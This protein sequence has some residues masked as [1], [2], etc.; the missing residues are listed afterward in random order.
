MIR[1]GSIIA[2]VLTVL[3]LLRIS[4]GLAVAFGTT[5]ESNSV[6]A[7]RYLA[8]ANTGEA[9]N[10]GMVMLGIGVVI[11][12]LATIARNTGSSEH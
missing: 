10:E 4:L 7:E 8:A 3:G 11:G 6:F 1:L 9:I 12:L 5:A 2:W